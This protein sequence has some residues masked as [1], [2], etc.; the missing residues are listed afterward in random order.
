MRNRKYGSLDDNLLTII[1]NKFNEHL[2]NKKNKKFKD[3]R[4]IKK[5]IGRPRKID[6]KHVIICAFKIINGSLL[7][8]LLKNPKEQSSYEKYIR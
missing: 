5:I 7:E 6:I 8:D 1:L 4:N 3:K 2:I